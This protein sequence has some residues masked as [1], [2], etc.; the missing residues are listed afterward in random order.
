MYIYTFFFFSIVHS[1]RNL[2]R[3]CTHRPLRSGQLTFL[4]LVRQEKEPCQRKNIPTMLH[5]ASLQFRMHHFHL[6]QG[7]GENPQIPDFKAVFLSGDPERNQIPLTER[8][9]RARLPQTFSLH[10]RQMRGIY[11]FSAIFQGFT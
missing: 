6:D 7:E 9:P 10:L 8:S 11:L 5:S 2:P 3:L 4:C 1:D